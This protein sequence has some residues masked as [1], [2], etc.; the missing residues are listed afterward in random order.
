MR[1]ARTA[2]NG[3]HQETPKY[4][5]WV[6]KALRLYLHLLACTGDLD[7]LQKAVPVL[8]QGP[9]WVKEGQDVLADLAR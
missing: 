4:V 3:L 2:G 7:M 9:G 8:Q 1:P 5:Y 6:C